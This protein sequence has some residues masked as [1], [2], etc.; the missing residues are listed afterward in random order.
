[1]LTIC[2]ERLHK[3]V[4]RISSLKLCICKSKLVRLLPK[5]CYLPYSVGWHPPHAVVFAPTIAL[6]QSTGSWMPFSISKGYDGKTYHLF[7]PHRSYLFY[8][9]I[10]RFQRIQDHKFDDIRGV[11]LNEVRLSSI[12]T[13][14]LQPPHDFIPHSVWTKF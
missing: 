3:E 5:S 11:H 1:M 8:R 2:T 4:R 9:G 14:C 12:S 10:Y 6:N 13:F 7:L